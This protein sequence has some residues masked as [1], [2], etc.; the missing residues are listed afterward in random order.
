MVRLA[1]PTDTS[2]S[3][4]VCAEV[5][6]VIPALGALPLNKAKGGELLNVSVKGAT[7]GGKATVLAFCQGQAR[8]AS[9]AVTTIVVEAL[10]AVSKVSFL[11]TSAP[12]TES[13]PLGRVRFLSWERT[14]AS[15]FLDWRKRS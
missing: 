11:G 10:P 8:S 2:L 12:A 4:S 13:P 15:F 14:S 1:K 5:S 6:P 9:F 3:R 7:N